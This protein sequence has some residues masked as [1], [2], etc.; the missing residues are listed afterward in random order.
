MRSRPVDIAVLPDRVAGSICLIVAVAMCIGA[1]AVSFGG[2][3]AITRTYG[4]V[5]LTP[6]ALGMLW[7]GADLVTGMRLSRTWKRISGRG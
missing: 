6:P 3:T 7:I 5:L 4:A 2:G 1:G